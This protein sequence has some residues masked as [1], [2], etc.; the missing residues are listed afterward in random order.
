[1][2]R[3]VIVAQAAR[4]A[5]SEI[6]A[7][8]MQGEEKEITSVEP[9]T[10]LCYFAASLTKEGRITSTIARPEV[11]LRNGLKP[12]ISLVIAELSNSSLMHFSLDP[13]YRV[14]PLLIED[15]CRVTQGFDGVQID[16]ESVSRDDADYFIGFLQDLK[17]RLPPGTMLSVAVPARTEP[18]QDA[19]DYAR[20]AGIADRLIV[21]AYDEH[22][23]TSSPGPVASLS[24]CSKVVDYAKSVIA[25]DKLVMGL[26]LYGRAW[27]DK[28][29]ARALRFRSVEDLVAEKKSSPSYTSE[30]GSYFEYTESVLVR[31]FYD[32]ERSIMEK[33]QLYLDRSV[34]SVAFWRLGL[35]SPQLWKD[36]EI[37]GAETTPGAGPGMDPVADQA[38][39]PVRPPGER[40]PYEDQGRAR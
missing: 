29:L 22:W 28:K 21:M 11:T 5:F 35:G 39:D 8:L 14:R 6:W 20:I 34:R 23:S 25:S 2:P 30:Q 27:Q 10:H 1:M 19:Y 31:V 12:Q 18:I 26:P 7:Y 24:W 16:F 4:P 33:L 9:I 3:D 36:I 40:P 15:I 13:E 32:D 38:A 37:A 17:V